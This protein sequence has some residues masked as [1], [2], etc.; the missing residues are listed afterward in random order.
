MVNQETHGFLESN[1]HWQIISSYP[2]ILPL[3]VARVTASRA[4]SCPAPSPAG[5]HGEV[6]RGWEEGGERRV[7]RGGGEGKGQGG[8]GA[9]KKEGACQRTRCVTRSRDTA[10]RRP[11]SSLGVARMGRTLMGRKS[12]QSLLNNNPCPSLRNNEETFLSVPWHKENDLSD[13]CRPGTSL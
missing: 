10:G 2:A 4:T 12:Q 5:E 13:L 6:G 8:G 7:G 11:K 1:S 9:G 3:M